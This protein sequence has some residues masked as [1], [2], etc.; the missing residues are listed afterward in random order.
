MIAYERQLGLRALLHERHV[1][2]IEETAICDTRRQ[3]STYAWKLKLFKRAV[4]AILALG[5]RLQ[6]V[7]GYARIAGL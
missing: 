5:S 7:L 6:I 1:T 4:S 3:L 2:N